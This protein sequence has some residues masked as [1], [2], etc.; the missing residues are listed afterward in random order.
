MSS[1]TELHLDERILEALDAEGYQTPT[2][3]Q[4]ETIPALMDGRDVLGVAQTGTGKT[5]AFALPIL[6]H[7]AVNPP[8]NDRPIRALMLTP[9]RELAAQIGERLRVYGR[10]LPLYSTVI[11][12]GVGQSPQVKALRR[13]VDLLV[14]TPGR[15]LDLYEQGHVDLGGV[16]HFVLD[17]ADRM[18]DMG[19]S[20]DVE[21]ILR[22]M[23]ERRQNLMFSATMPKAIG[24]LANNMLYQPVSVDI[25]PEAPTTD[26]IEQYVSFVRKADKRELLIDLLEGQMVSCGIVFTR[27]KHG[28]NRLAKQL[29]KVGI[30]ADSIHGDKSQ[31]AR[32]RALKRFKNG[33]VFILV[34]TDIAS[35][36]IDVEDITHVFNFDLPNE[37]EVYIHRIGRTARAGR[38]GLAYSFCDE[39]ESGYLVGIQ[40]LLGHDIEV[41]EDQPY[42][43][44]K[45]RPKPG[46]K[47]GRVKGSPVGG[48]SRRGT[49]KGREM[50]RYNRGGP[51]RREHQ[52]RSNKP[53]GQGR[54]Q[55]N[56][57][58]RGQ[59]SDQPN[60]PSGGRP[61]Q[62]NHRGGKQQ[63]RS[64]AFNNRSSNQSNRRPSRRNDR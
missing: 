11:F 16:E 22:L 10:H 3:V 42:H 37:P 25:S 12:G 61:P 39:T 17:E 53:S 48:P 8:S 35:R 13:G 55:N 57:S 43:F 5:A 27:T 52:Q 41:L 50:R 51:K 64:N 26:R 4:A 28:A 30:S 59:R 20:K 9:T 44:E 63:G 31:T 7:L 34:A 46:Q 19:F 62:S 54:N 15:L 33:E 45:A 47:P 29:E 56:R 58:Q 6:H 24:S 49:G 36:G 32:T 2:P 23:P 21:R 18:L 60:R 14:A 40:R 1:F 38:E